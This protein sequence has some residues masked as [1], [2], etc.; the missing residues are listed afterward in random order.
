M[1]A[2][3]SMRARA[4]CGAAAVALA[5]FVLAPGAARAAYIQTNLQSSVLG[6]AASQ[7]TDLIN[8]IGIALG[9]TSPLIVADNGNGLSTLYNGSGTKQGLVISLASGGTPTGAAFNATGDFNGDLFLYATNQGQI[10]GWRPALGTSAEILADLGGGGASYTGLAIGST[11]AGTYL[12]AANF[13]QNRIDVFPSLGAP[14]VSGSFTDPTLP[15]GTSVFNIQRIG[16]DL[17]VTYTGAAGGIVDV[18]DLD[19]NLERRLTSG[20]TLDEPWGMALAPAGFGEFGGA[21]LVGNHGD[22]TISAFDPAAGT[23]LGQLADGVGDPL[24][25]DGLWALQFGNGGSGG[26]P[27]ELFFTAGINVGADGLFGKITSTGGGTAVPE[28]ATMTLFAGGLGFLA[29]GRKRRPAPAA[30]AHRR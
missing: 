8:P 22:G 1:G 16:S 10:A 29:L 23:F 30:G 9:A 25:N 20:G 21:L 19:G 27:D 4:G 11:I 26:L 5:A 12:F 3:N 13:S 14:A 24:V 2:F 15:A 17:Y 7:D 28:P 18:F 6:L